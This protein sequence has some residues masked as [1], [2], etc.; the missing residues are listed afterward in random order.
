MLAVA[1]VD[2][3]SEVYKGYEDWRIGDRQGRWIISWA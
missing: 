1:A 3:V 2:V